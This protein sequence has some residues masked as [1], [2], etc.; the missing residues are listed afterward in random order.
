MKIFQR[1]SHCLATVNNLE[2]NFGYLLR[3]KALQLDGKAGI[4]KISHI[5]PVVVVRL[6]GAKGIHKIE[7]L[8]N[9]LLQGCTQAAE[10]TTVCLFRAIK[11]DQQFLVKRILRRRPTLIEYPGPNGYLPLANAI[12]FSTMCIVD[13]ILTYGAS[14]H[15]G[16]PN[17]N[18]TPL[19]VNTKKL[20]LCN[21]NFNFKV[22]ETVH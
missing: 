7:F 8:I 16:N 12:A 19:H 1:T 13:V 4:Y 22:H 18:R 17:N 14:V 11:K 9:F 15:V 20:C 2:D 5:S 21:S 3:V 10:V 6:I